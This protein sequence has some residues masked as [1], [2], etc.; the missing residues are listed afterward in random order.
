MKKHLKGPGLLAALLLLAASSPAQRFM[1]VATS[2]WDDINGMY[3]NPANLAGNHNSV[4]VSLIGMGVGADNN[5]GTFS[6]LSDLT[7]G[8]AIDFTNSGNKTFSMLVPVFELRG[9][10]VVIGLNDKLKQSF[11]FS[12]RIRVINQFNNFDQ[13]IYNTVEN[14]GSVQKQDYEFA[15]SKFNWSAHA[16]NEYGLSYALV[17]FQQGPHTIKVGATVRFLGGIGYLGLK[18]D[19]LKIK[20]SAGTD[21][22]FASNSDLEFASNLVSVNNAKSDGLDA[23]RVFNN[24]FGAKA[25]GFGGDIGVSYSYQPET[26]GPSDA[27]DKSPNSDYLFRVSAAITDFGAIKYKQGEN[28]IVNVTGN[29]YVT[30]QGLV[31]NSKSYTEFRNYAVKQG[32][33]ADTAS[34]DTKLYMPTTLIVG[35]DVHAWKRIFIN[36]TGAMNLANRQHFG[37]SYYSQI[38]VTPRYDSRV[39]SFGLP[40][41]YSMLANDMKVGM[42]IRFYGFY[43]GSDDM[44]AVFS[45][46][47][48]GFNA[49]FGG[50]IPIRKKNHEPTFGS[51]K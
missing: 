51:G 27:N 39:L 19:N 16:W 28:Y 41:T 13:S 26:S 42:G 48:H 37:N 14:P 46:S 32:F 31:D 9:P 38:T 45:N 30:G 49:Y 8:K 18:S 35:A 47:Q 36:A 23:S 22:F 11:A 24:L 10:G 5:L 12:T 44:M 1:G 2:G 40:I 33:T 21:S 43:F 3:L 15:A 20:Y 17:P 6:K 29:G 34:V 50:F 4:V 7:N 25:R